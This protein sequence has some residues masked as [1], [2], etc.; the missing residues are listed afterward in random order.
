MSH[1]PYNPQ[2]ILRDGKPTAV[3]LDI[4]DY[5]ALLERLEQVEDL[6]AIRAMKADDR[7]TITFEEYLREKD[8]GVSR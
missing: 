7:Q 4:E 2:V 8:R 1:D 5:E 3:I 6:R